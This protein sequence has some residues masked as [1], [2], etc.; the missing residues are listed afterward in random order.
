MSRKKILITYE[1]FLPAYKA[2]GP[3]QSIANLCR[4]LKEEYQFY[5]I[6]SNSDHKENKIL[7]RIN[8]N[9]WNDFENGTASIYYLS[10]SYRQSKTIS[11]L[12]KKID[13]D[14]LFVN[15]LF[16]PLFTVAPLLSAKC[17]KIVS[18]RGMLHPGALS[19]KTLKKR[20]FITLMKG[21]GLYKKVLFHATD[22]KEKLFVEN[23]FGKKIKIIV[24]QNFSSTIKQ[25][26]RTTKN[27]GSLRM[28]SIAL[29]SPMKN[30]ALVLEALQ[31]VNADIVYD[32]YGP[33]KD[34]SYWVKCLKIIGT[35]PKNIQVN[36]KGSIEPEKVC[37]LFADYH[38][39]I[40]PSKSENFGHAIY[41]ALSSGLPVITSYFTPWNQL[42]ENNAG[43]NVDISNVSSI[44][45]AIEEAAQ[46]DDISYQSMKKNAVTFAAKKVDVE[47]IKDQYRQLFGSLV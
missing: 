42:N 47:K 26:Q 17:T 6:C 27:E 41:E 2:G 4:Q 21:L 1:Y 45:S 40:L 25:L 8:S 3:I 28:I 13:P 5:I 9:E 18:V 38:C 19:Q 46:L 37:S 24:A 44:T 23:V 33:V 20:I 34:E 16:S 15:G 35:L 11:I 12:I 39:F 22:E 31:K 7:E 10:N 29:I 43:W 30:H 36:Y 14:Y 32:I